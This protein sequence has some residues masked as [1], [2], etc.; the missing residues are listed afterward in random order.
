M[1]FSD[2]TGSCEP[3]HLSWQG[4]QLASSAL[5]IVAALVS[6]NFE[7]LRD[8]D[9]SVA[10]RGD[11]GQLSVARA[12]AFRAPQDLNPAGV[13]HDVVCKGLPE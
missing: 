3:R 13:G 1:T 10:K 11:L 12:S 6:T 8:P 5:E 7:F 2:V 4:R 9:N